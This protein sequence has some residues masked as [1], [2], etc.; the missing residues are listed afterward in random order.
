MAQ[1][2]GYFKNNV[3]FTEGPFVICNPCS[4]GW[5]IEVEL[6]GHKCPVLP[7]ISIYKLMEQLG[8]SGMTMDKELVEKVCD[9]L[10]QMV[11][12]EEIALDSG[13]WAH[14]AA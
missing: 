7:N 1:E 4:N 6:K 10:N 8:M 14:K 11:R 9:T 12:D 3:V 5:R 13:F 2:V